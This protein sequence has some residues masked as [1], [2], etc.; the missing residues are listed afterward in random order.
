MNSIVTLFQNHKGSELFL[1]V[2]ATGLHI[3]DKSNKLTPEISFP[4]SEIKNIS[5]DDRK[6]TIKLVDKTAPNF[7]FFSQNLK[8]NKLVS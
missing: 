8:M 1:G 5:Y 3:Y 7:V 2:C 6:F 4:W